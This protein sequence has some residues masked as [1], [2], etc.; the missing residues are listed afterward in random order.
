MNIGKLHVL[1]VHFP[2]ALA[3]CAVLADIL[4]LVTRKDRFRDAGV[5]CLVLAAVSAL[6]VVITGLAMA[7]SQE[8]VGDY[9]SIVT[10]HKYLGITSFTIAALAAVIRLSCRQRLKG[11]WLIAY[12]V[13]ILA[14][15][16]SIAFT[17]H[18]GGMLVHGKNFLS[19]IF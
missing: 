11:L 13:L 14:L 7:R 6:P 18:Y 12:C 9:L 17:G 1:L 5:Y 15:A 8:F 4:W 3:F 16:I 10:T 2:I 19:N